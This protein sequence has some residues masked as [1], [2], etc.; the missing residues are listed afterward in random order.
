[1]SINTGKVSVRAFFKI[2]AHRADEN[3]N[4]LAGSRR[5]L[6]DWF[7]NL[8]TN[9]GMDRIE[10][11]YF[12]THVQVGTSSAAPAFTDTTLGARVGGASG[13]VASG[14]A[15]TDAG[16]YYSEAIGTYTFAQGAATGNLSEIG[17]AWASSGSLFSRA[18][19]RDGVGNPTTLV[20]TAID[21]L[22]VTYSMRFYF[23][24]VDVAGSFTVEGVLRDTVS[25]VSGRRSDAALCLYQYGMRGAT[26][27]NISNCGTYS[28]ALGATT[29]VP[30]TAVGSETN[31][32]TIP[33]Y[34][35][36]SYYVDR[37]YSWAVTEGNGTIAAIAEK[38]GNNRSPIN[39]QVSFT[40]PL[41]KDNTRT[42]TFTVRRS[43]ARYT[44]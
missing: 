32:C 39:C 5:V 26:G 19:I 41:V 22:T 21:I 31:T 7:P 18:L 37:V 6:A 20:V 15:G 25:R 36:G 30:A 9:G 4:E 23:N 10:Q 43:W 8:I 28:G 27:G 12:M 42:M 24:E 35:A 17:A 34:V 29:A 44:P 16:G 40:P 38:N 33:A 3:G 13:S 14:T 11:G 1:M 2:E